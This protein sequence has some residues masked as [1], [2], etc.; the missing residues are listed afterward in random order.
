M[1]G[2]TRTWTLA[3]TYTPWTP[4]SRLPERPRRAPGVCWRGHALE[5]PARA[6]RSARRAGAPAE[7]AGSDAFQ[8][9]LPRAPGRGWRRPGPRPL[10]GRARPHRHRA[11]STHR[12]PART[13]LA[14]PFPPPCGQHAQ[15]TSTPRRPPGTWRTH[16]DPHPPTS[17]DRTTAST[18]VL[19][20]NKYR[21]HDEQVPFSRT[22][23]RAEWGRRVYRRTSQQ[24]WQPISG[25]G[26]RSAGPA[27]GQRAW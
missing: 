5:P 20:S 21:S 27:T 1:W 2:Q 26:N 24:I 3:V 11:D 15:K 23:R 13:P 10:P 6:S 18:P 14:G 16:P 4:W 19:T 17:P 9:E 22:E 7:Q 12:R 25:P 8:D